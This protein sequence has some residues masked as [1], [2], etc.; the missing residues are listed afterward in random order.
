[1]AAVDLLQ[2]A[3]EL[4]EVA[5]AGAVRAK[6][7]RHQCAAVAAASARA[8]FDAIRLTPPDTASLDRAVAE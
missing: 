8:A 4:V 2:V 5:V 7:S 6:G 3:G 1:M